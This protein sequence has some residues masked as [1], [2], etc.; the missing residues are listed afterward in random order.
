M[1]SRLL[2]EKVKENLN[3]T[4]KQTHFFNIYYFIWAMSLKNKKILCNIHKSI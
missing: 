2:V 1:S 3:I 4:H